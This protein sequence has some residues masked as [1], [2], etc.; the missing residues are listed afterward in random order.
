MK[1]NSQIFFCLFV[2]HVFQNV[3]FS[4]VFWGASCIS[5]KYSLFFPSTFWALHSPL[6]TFTPV[7]MLTKGILFIGFAAVGVNLPHF[8]NCGWGNHNMSPLKVD[9]VLHFKVCAALGSPQWCLWETVWSETGLHVFLCWFVT[10]QV[11]VTCLSVCLIYLVIFAALLGLCHDVP[12]LCALLVNRSSTTILSSDL[13]WQIKKES[14][15]VETC[16]NFIVSH[17][18]V[19]VVESFVATTESFCLEHAHVRCFRTLTR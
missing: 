17:L 4:E 6:F 18:Y 16:H 14:S 5:K 10:I 19:L 11:A 9:L 12:V 15:K 7:I 13:V 1:L 2:L 8:L 3:I